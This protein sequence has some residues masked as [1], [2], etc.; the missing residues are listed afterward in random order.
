[1][2]RL[3]ALSYAA[4]KLN[5]HF[6]LEINTCDLR[7]SYPRVV[8]GDVSEENLGKYLGKSPCGECLVRMIWRVILRIHIAP[9]RHIRHI[10]K[11]MPT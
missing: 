7:G 11:L 10:A 3:C 8:L 6:D 1:M 2:H 5:R 9:R 4:F